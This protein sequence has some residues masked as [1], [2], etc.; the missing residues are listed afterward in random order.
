MTMG[1]ETCIS[2]CILLFKNIE[3]KRFIKSNFVGLVKGSLVSLIQEVPC[4][5]DKSD[6]AG[7]LPL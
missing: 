3:V 1:T 6:G 2:R 7:Q 4:I 5:M